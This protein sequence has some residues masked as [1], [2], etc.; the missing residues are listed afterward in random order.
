MRLRVSSLVILCGIAG[1]IAA[2]VLWHFA[3]TRMGVM[4][5]LHVRNIP[6]TAIIFHPTL[7][8]GYLAAVTTGLIA[9]LRAR[10]GQ[11][12]EPL[13]GIIVSGTWIWLSF[14]PQALGLAT[15]WMMLALG[16]FLTGLL[17]RIDTANA[18]LYII[19][20][21]IACA[22]LL[23]LAEAHVEEMQN[24]HLPGFS[25]ESVLFYP[26]SIWILRT[27]V[28]IG[29]LL[30][31]GMGNSQLTVG[32]YGMISAAWIWISFVPEVVSIEASWVLIALG[33]CLAG[34]VGRQFRSGPDAM[35]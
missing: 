15:P 16:I 5:D 10:K 13:A 32:A 21:L 7:K 17:L 1:M 33:L 27:A 2:A 9:I 25:L 18:L 6:L 28:V 11:R 14:A 19:F 30:M 4:R 8:W 31:A 35:P 3:E 34:L 26:L 12:V 29:F 23:Y 20:A 22:S 24:A